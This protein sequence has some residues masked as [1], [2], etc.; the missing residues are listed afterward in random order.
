MTHPL[1]DLLQRVHRVLVRPLAGEGDQGV[2]L[3]L[4]A[5]QRL[6]HGGDHVLGR[7][8][9]KGERRLARKQRVV[10]AHVRGRGK[11][12]GHQRLSLFSWIDG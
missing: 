3:R 11:G 8:A 1:A 9:V 12:I 4:G 6:A 7:D 5:G 2:Q 10:G